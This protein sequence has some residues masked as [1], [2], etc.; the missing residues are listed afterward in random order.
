MHSL[1]SLLDAARSQFPRLYFISDEELIEVL[2]VSHDAQQ[3][4]P[5][6]RKCFPGIINISFEVPSF[7]NANALGRAALANYS[8][9]GKST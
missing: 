7:S 3:L 1:G 5:V 4:L 9:N 8:L 2:A 6:T